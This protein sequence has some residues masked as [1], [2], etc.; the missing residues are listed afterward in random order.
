MTARSTS[1]S[2]TLEGSSPQPARWKALG[3]GFVAA[4]TT[5]GAADFVS[6][7]VAGARYGYELLWAVALGCVVKVTLAEAVGRWHLAGRTMFSGW[8][9][10]GRGFSWYFAIYLVVYGVV[11]A[12]ACMS[13]A[14]LPLNHAMPGLSTPSWGVVCGLVTFA[15]VLANRYAAF[16]RI[17]T[18]LIGIVFVS[19]VGLAILVA[20]GL[21]ELAD[22]LVVRAPD[23]SVRYTLAIIG[24]VGGSATLVAYGYWISTKGWRGRSWLSTMRLDN[25]VGYATVGLSAVAM[26]VLGAKLLHVSGSTEISNEDWLSS[27]HAALEKDLGAL[28]ANWFLVAFTLTTLSTL[29]GVWHGVS[30]VFADFVRETW[31][32]RQ[33]AVNADRSLPFRLYLAWLTFPAMVIMFLGKPVSLVL[34]AGVLAASFLPVLGITLLML[35]NSRSIPRALRNGWISNALLTLSVAL[36][37]YLFGLEVAGYF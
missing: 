22:G 26:M 16:E 31:P 24:G 14:A 15:L 30:L 5:V 34:A 29:F 2:E 17:M 4:A 13:A 25:R 8:A 27:I 21:G 28:A 36:F 1:S 12:A 33:R 6:S 7:S 10:L 23:G 37:I 32:Q 20:P 9:R 3:P 19:I 35:L 11:L 18:V